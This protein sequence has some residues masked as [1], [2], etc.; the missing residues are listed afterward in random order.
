MV[1]LRS[2]LL[3]VLV[4]VALAKPALSH[5]DDFATD[6]DAPLFEFFAKVTA[7]K[8]VP[9]INSNT[10]AFFAAS[11]ANGTVTWELEVFH[12]QNLTMAH[13]HLVSI[14]ESYPFVGR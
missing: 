14:C 6:D 5:S 10:T 3:A 8:S 9:P 12:V 11:V 13:I 4:V 1:S 7:A 2:S